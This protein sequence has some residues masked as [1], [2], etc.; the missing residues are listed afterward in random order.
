M[1]KTFDRIVLFGRRPGKNVTETLAMVYDYLRQRVKLLAI[2]AETAKQF[3]PPEATIISSNALKSH[4]DLA[5]VVGG[6]GS[7]LHAAA[8]LAAQDIPVVGINRGRLGFLTDICPDEMTDIQQILAGNYHTEKRF[9]LYTDVYHQDERIAEENALNDVVLLPG[10][11][12]HMIEFEVRINDEFVC[13]HRSDGM[14][15]ATPTGSTAYSLS[16]GGPILDPNIDA[17][18]LVPICPHTLTSRPFVTD[19]N[20]TITLVVSKQNTSSPGISC[21]GRDRIS[22]SPGDRITICK[23]RQYLTL[24]H[25][26]THNYYDA[27]RSKLFWST[28]RC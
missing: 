3:H 8:E 26:T 7:M 13:T 20:D 19:A 4:V 27:L 21:D 24:I 9:L 28:K 17:I 5:I 10:D 11:I 2:D 12:A 23:N 25:P 14:I 16:A 6:D 22:L 18:V 1:N 15:V